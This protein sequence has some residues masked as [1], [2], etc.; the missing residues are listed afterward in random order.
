MGRYNTSSLKC[1]GF[2]IAACNNVLRELLFETACGDSAVS[3]FYAFQTIWN[4]FAKLVYVIRNQFAIL[5]FS[6]NG[7]LSAGIPPG[8]LK[9]LFSPFSIIYLQ[10][11]FQIQ[12]GSLYEHIVHEKSVGPRRLPTKIQNCRFCFRIQTK[13]EIGDAKFLSAAGSEDR[14]IFLCRIC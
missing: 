5:I 1:N 10:I 2:G 14:P 13:H 6:K 3:C 12:Y 11:F 7:Q 8:F 9:I 4:R